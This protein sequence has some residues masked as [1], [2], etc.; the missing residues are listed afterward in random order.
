MKE[1]VI[2]M[3]RRNDW[4]KE[5]N[6]IRDWNMKKKQEFDRKEIMESEIEV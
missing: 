4:Y 3:W 2:E 1:P 6:W 5:I